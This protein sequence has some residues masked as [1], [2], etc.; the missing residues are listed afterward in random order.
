[1]KQKVELNSSPE[2]KPGLNLVSAAAISIGATIGAGIFAVTGIAAGEAGSAL[3]LSLILAATCTLLTAISFI[4]LISWK[5]AEGSIYYYSRELVSPFIGF[6]VG[7]IWIISTLFTGATVALSFSHYFRDVIPLSL[8]SNQI[9]LII[10]F[11]FTILNYIGL[12]ESAFVNNLFV[13]LKILILIAFVV[14]GFFFIKPEN[15][16]PLSFSPPHIFIAAAIIFFAYGGF[17]RV[18]IIAEEI[19]NPRKTVPKAIL[20][21]LLI[22]TVIYFLVTF[23]A[24]GLAG[25]VRLSHSGAPLSTAIRQTGLKWTGLAVGLG[26]VL[27]TASVLLTSILGVSR[28]GLAMSRQRDLPAAFQS[29]HPKFHTP[30]AGVVATGLVMAL[31]AY[32]FDLSKVVSISSFSLL[33]YYS[34]A[35][36]SALRLKNWSRS[37]PVIISWA[38]LIFCLAIGFFLLFSQ[39]STL[40]ISLICLLIGT[41]LYLFRKKSA[42]F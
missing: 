41:I 22:S 38:G 10:I 36:I 14:I 12:E 7:W 16:R 19:K 8:K 26:G 20:L 35:N 42:N 28:M 11:L 23:V 25:A 24:L 2:L 31:L 5:P 9:A 27:A 40:V 29:I 15:F 6:L 4:E 21:S 37:Y 39:P 33:A 3:L 34:M 13:L 17:A 30:A 18:A 1:M 32:F